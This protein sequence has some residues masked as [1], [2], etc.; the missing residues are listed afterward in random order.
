MLFPFS[1]RFG[2]SILQL[3]QLKKK[4]G[5]QY[6]NEN[7]QKMEKIN[8]TY[9]KLTHNQQQQV[10]KKI[11][12]FNLIFEIKKTSKSQKLYGEINQRCENKIGSSMWNG[13][14]ELQEQYQCSTESSK[15]CFRKNHVVAISA[16]LIEKLLTFVRHS[17]L[18]FILGVSFVILYI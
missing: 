1:F 6:S 3:P 5:T 10:K 7:K 14:G 15:P 9:Q 12:S 18:L 11:L 16:Y 2:I 8:K 4:K 13:Q 17:F